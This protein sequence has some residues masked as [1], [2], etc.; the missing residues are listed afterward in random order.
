MS[1]TTVTVRTYAVALLGLDASMVE[2]EVDVSDNLPGMVVIGLPDAALNQGRDRVRSAAANS[3]LPIANRRVTVNLSPAALPKHG[4]GFDLAIAIGALATAGGLDLAAIARTVHLGELALDG[5]VRPVP[6]V[7]PALVAAARAGFERAMVPV[8]NL[9]EAS[10]VPGIEVIG[11][12]SLREAAILYGADLD[13]VEVQP[14]LPPTLVDANERVPELGDVV[15]NGE[16]VEALVTAAAGGHHLF[17]VGPPGAGKTMLASR[18]PGLLPDLGEAAAL[19]V[20]SLRSIAGGALTALV[21]RPPFEHPHHTA[22]P[23]AIVGGG[24]SRI[25]PGAAVMASHGVLFLDEAPEFTAA[26]LDALRQPLESG[27]VEI[28]RAAAVARFPANFQLVMAANPCPCGK[29]GTE[30]TCE[31]PASA[32]R[33]YLARISGPLMDRVDLQLSVH[34]ISNAELSIGAPTMTSADAR[35]LV[36][37][38]RAAA[39]DRLRG[40]EW[41]LNSQVPGEHLLGPLRLPRSVLGSLAKALERGAVTMRGYIRVIRVA[42]TLADLDG[43]TSPA[44]E[45]IDRA[46]HLRAAA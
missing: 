23:A 20:S 29:W 2:V 13:P 28:H 10:L 36:D 15:G 14:V 40:T 22:T 8:G 24:S 21:R 33:R 38:A 35:A 42:W 1:A 12:A 6:G 17:M 18:L 11:V 32:R 5:R 44:A 27:V 9:A 43:A 37:S 19:E 39:A 7:L 34:R 3:G 41:T 26:A 4:S 46:L 31:C 25:R 16:A 45:H 30:L